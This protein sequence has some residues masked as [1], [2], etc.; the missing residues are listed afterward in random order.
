[1]TD[2]FKIVPAIMTRF[3]L[4]RW[5]GWPIVGWW[6]ADSYSEDYEELA[7]TVRMCGGRL[8]NRATPNQT[9]E[10]ERT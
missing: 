2:R 3:K 5:V 1:M 7:E 8:V 9:G 4:M 6:E 10:V